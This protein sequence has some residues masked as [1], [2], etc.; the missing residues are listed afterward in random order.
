MLHRLCEKLRSVSENSNL[1]SSEIKRLL[2]KNRENQAIFKNVTELNLPKFLILTRWGTWLVFMKE[3]IINYNKYK[4]FITELVYR[5]L[6]EKTLLMKFID[7]SFVFELEKIDQCTFLI[8]SILNL[9]SKKLSTCDQ[10]R[11]VKDL[12]D[13]LKTHFL[14]EK[15]QSTSRKKHGFEFFLKT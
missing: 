3:I 12:G 11:I 4:A 6:V 8:E 7:N 2:V 14:C 9:E 15:I 13:R 10:I 5:E 1:I